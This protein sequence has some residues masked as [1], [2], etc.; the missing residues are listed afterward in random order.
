MWLAGDLLGQAAD[1]SKQPDGD[2]GIRFPAAV[3]DLPDRQALPKAKLQ[4]FSVL[5]LELSDP[6]FERGLARVPVLV[7]F[8]PSLAFFAVLRAFGI[9]GESGLRPRALA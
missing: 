8:V 7:F 1:Q 9:S 6:G 2:P 4:E 3:G 5:A